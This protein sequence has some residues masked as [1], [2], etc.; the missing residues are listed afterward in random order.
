MDGLKYLVENCASLWTAEYERKV[1]N[2]LKN[3]EYGKRKERE[4][5]HLREKYHI[6]NF[7]GI[8][9]I[10]LKRNSRIMATKESVIEIIKN[11][12]ESIGHK[13]ERKTYQKIC[14][15]YAKITRKIIEEYIRQCERCNNNDD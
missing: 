11:V 4:E 9:K 3:W 7:T 8:E 14:E 2:I 13:G 6:Q 1:I 5:Y 15:N 10:I 12:H